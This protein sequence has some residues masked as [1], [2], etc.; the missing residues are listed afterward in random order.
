MPNQ[1]TG[2]VLAG[3][4]SR[5][6]G[7]PKAFATR[8]GI[9]FYQYSINTLAPYCHSIVF[10]TRPEF[11]NQFSFEDDSITVINDVAKFQGQGPLAGI[12]SA[13]EEV[14]AEWYIVLPVDVPFIEQ[15]VIEKLIY[16]IEDNINAVVPIVGEKQQP[17][18]ACYHHSVHKQIAEN[19][20]NEK[21]SLQQL[22]DHIRVKYIQLNNELP[23]R[24]INRPEDL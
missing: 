4:E 6:F 3:G 20:T 23:F 14:S 16:N 15:W 10:V 22:F 2:I 24:N 7:S 5:R 13:I 21:L 12:Y 9:P 19:L 8:N 17:L 18:I 11:H 1:I